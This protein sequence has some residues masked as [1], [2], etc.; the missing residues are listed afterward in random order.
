M[1]KLRVWW[2]PQVGACD[3]FYVPVE[4]VEEAKKVMDLLAAYDAFQFQSMIKPD[5]TNVGGLEMFDEETGE[6][7]DWYL[8]TEDDY[9]ED[10]DEY[11]EQCEK[12]EELD[13]FN[14]ELFKQ[15]DWAEIERMT[16]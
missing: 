15:V 1:S 6:W 7:N 4:S 10:V 3:P 13:E 12:A 8:E 14:Q 9:F 11:C 16:R 5:Y 2:I